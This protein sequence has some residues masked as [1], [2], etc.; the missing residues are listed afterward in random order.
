[1]DFRLYHLIFAFGLGLLLNL[2]ATA[3]VA[4]ER[5]RFVGQVI[6]SEVPN[7]GWPMEFES[8]KIFYVRV[9]KVKKGS[10]KAKYVRIAYGH[11]PSNNPSST[12]PEAMFNGQ[13]RWEF[14][15]SAR[16]EFDSSVDVSRG[17]GDWFDEKN[18]VKVK[19]AEIGITKNKPDE[20]CFT[21][22]ML[23]K[24]EPIAGFEQEAISLEKLGVIAGYWLDFQNRKGFKEIKNK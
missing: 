14:E 18:K 23:K 1:M 5:V 19:C 16:E 17:E 6:G 12:L 8:L 24:L 21:I 10:L 20:D 22:P 11:N 3:V 4:K 2:Q 9:E 13:T 15:V 7:M